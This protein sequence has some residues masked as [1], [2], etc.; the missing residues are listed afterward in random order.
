M[1]KCYGCN[2]RILSN[3]VANGLNGGNCVDV[4][5]NPQCGDPEFLT[6]L[7][8]VVYDEIGINICRTIPFGDIIDDFPTTAFVN[9]EVIDISYETCGENAVTVSPITSRPNCYEVTLTNLSVTF[10][11]KLYDCCKRLLATETLCDVLYLPPCTKNSGYD[12][13]TNPTS[14]SLELFAPYGVVY[15]DGIAEKPTINF[16]GFSTTN[17]TLTQGLNLTAI[18]KVLDF[19]I[20][21][22]TITVGLTLVVSSVYFVQYQLPHNGKA[23]VSKGQ[24]TTSEES[25]CMSFVSGSLLDRNIKPLE[26]CN[27]GDSKEPCDTCDDES[28]CA[29]LTP[30]D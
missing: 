9:A 21:D 1:S 5:V 4:C 26:F 2:K 22:C 14:V 10:A 19:D 11:I 8:P 16:I 13:D 20:G 6:V 23:I 7:T 18:P 15:E 27:P 29:C 12:S 28:D 24:L 17:S 3:A 30:S 25:A